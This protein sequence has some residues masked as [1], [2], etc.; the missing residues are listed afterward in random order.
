MKYDGTKKIEQSIKRPDMIYH[1]HATDE[2]QLRVCSNKNRHLLSMYK[3]F[4]YT[5]R[6]YVNMIKMAKGYSNVRF[7][8]APYTVKK[9]RQLKNVFTVCLKKGRDFTLLSLPL[10]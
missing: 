5:C 10:E 8:A 6:P 1:L 9:R 2:V 3:Y 4:L 7:L